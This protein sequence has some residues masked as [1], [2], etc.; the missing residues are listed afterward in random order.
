MNAAKTLLFLAL[1][2][3]SCAALAAEAED[4]PPAPSIFV[5]EAAQDGM[6]EVELGKVALKKSQNAQVREFAQRMVTDHGK[7]NEELVA[8]AKT[9]GI[10]A[11]NK[12]DAEHQAVVKNLESQDSAAFDAEYLRHMNMDH[13]RT[14]A[15]F[16]SALKSPDTD[17]SGFAKK[18]LPTLQEHKELAARLPG[19]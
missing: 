1:T 6:T 13:T 19:K 5:T 14:I 3:A 9:K 17:L 10:D 8:L 18:T 2:C 11:P 16:E 12:L 7:A 15:L 4:T